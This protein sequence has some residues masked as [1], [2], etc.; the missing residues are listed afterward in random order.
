MACICTPAEELL[1]DLAE[2]ERNVQAQMEEEVSFRKANHQYDSH[3][4]TTQLL[5]AACEKLWTEKVA[6]DKASFEEHSSAL[7]YLCQHFQT[8]I[9][10]GVS[11]TV[12]K[13]K[14]VSQTPVPKAPPVGSRR[15]RFFAFCYRSD[16]PSQQ[17]WWLDM[18][19]RLVPEYQV[20]RSKRL[21]RVPATD[22]VAGDIVY[23]SAGQKAPAD[24]RILLRSEGTMVDVSHLT[25]QAND[26]RVCC[27]RPTSATVT[28]SRNMV[29]RDCHVVH[30]ALFCM[31][32][33]A[34][35]NS[36]IPVSSYR[37]SDDY[38]IPV[39]S[40]V[41]AGMQL[42]GCQT[43]FKSLCVKANF[44]CKSY[45]LF[46]QLCEIQTIVVLLTQELLEKGTV[47]K[48]CESARKLGRALVFVNCDCTLA[49]IQTLCSEVKCQCVEFEETANGPK[50]GLSVEDTSTTAGDVWRWGAPMLM[51]CLSDSDHAKISNLINTLNANKSVVAVHGISQGALLHFCQELGTPLRP[52]LYATSGF[53]FA[54]CFSYLAASNP[55]RARRPSSVTSNDAAESTTAGGSPSVPVSETLSKPGMSS[56][57]SVSTTLRSSSS[58]GKPA[59]SGITPPHPSETLKEVQDGP[60]GLVVTD[61]LTKRESSEV[62]EQCRSITV[63]VNS[64]G[65]VS[66][67]ADC[68]MLKSDLECLGQALEIVSRKLH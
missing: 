21:L 42:N 24:G 7:L 20:V 18:Q 45:K 29:L 22:L 53:H 44:F 6:L 2:L 5:L 25:S 17:G 31:I 58:T 8:S 61:M 37:G 15:R 26:V 64:L 52:L 19:R 11:D 51:R 50:S 39:D 41:P 49:A 32:V 23:L 9:E 46:E 35:Q 28:E 48:L 1:K 13:S 59:R 47:P 68:I 34:T 63:S 56:P 65:I 43:I 66:E 33:R 12:Y 14:I 62:E 36:F 4:E 30:G 16:F 55:H 40:N 60:S 38:S 67:S 57:A 3:E 27:P 10:T 54:Q